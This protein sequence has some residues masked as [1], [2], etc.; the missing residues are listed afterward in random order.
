MQRSSSEVR[1][2]LFGGLTAA[3]I[4]LPLAI[5]FGVLAFSPLGPDYRSQGALAG[6]YGAIFT[7]FFAAWLGGTPSQVTGP[8]GPMTVVMTNVFVHCLQ[9]GLPPESVPALAF[10]TVSLAGLIQVFLGTARV[11]TLI[12]YIPYPV[13]AG[14]MN[15]IA[16]II[17]T[18]QIPP[19]LGLASGQGLSAVVRGQTAVSWATLLVGA[20][21]FLI[22]WFAP[23]VTR[24]VPGAL[25]GLVLGTG[26]YYLLSSTGAKLGPV[27]GEIPSGM[28]K[29]T[30][31][32]V[33]PSLLAHLPVLLGP[34]L[35]LAVLGSLDSL[36]TSLV[37]DAAT[38]TRHNSNRELVGQGVGNFLSG[39]F[40]GVAGAGATVRTMVNIGAG[41]RNRL[42]GIAHSVVLLL[43]VLV[44]GPWAG[45]IPLVVLAGILMV[46]AIRMIDQWSGSLAYRFIGTVRQ[47]REIALNLA[48]VALVTLVTVTVDLMVAVGI[49]VLVAA[50]LF[51]AKMRSSILGATYY[52]DT[53]Y[54]RRERTPLEIDLLERR[55]HSTAIL[56]LHGPLFFGSADELVVAVR[57][58][59]PVERIIIDF[60]RVV[61]VDSSGARVLQLLQEEIEV[62]GG[63]LA[64]C[65]IVR[66]GP[67]WAFLEDLGV[68]QK[69]GE[70]YVFSDLDAALEWAENEILKACSEVP[71][72]GTPITFEE[73][74][75]VRGLS[76]EEM[77][78]LEQYLELEEFQSGDWLARAGEK[79]TGFYL[80][81]RGSA[82]AHQETNGARVRRLASF[83]PGSIVGEMG[84]VSERPRSANVRA[85]TEVAA[86]HMGADRFRLLREEHPALACKL[87]WN[88]ARELS[89]RLRRAHA[90]ILV[91][92]GAPR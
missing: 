20:V 51:I 91:L 18:S 46:T 92:E 25:L 5:A 19:V 84:V 27:I 77:S 45:R 15:G 60:R 50:A 56:E 22:V 14:F 17:F 40:G 6:L 63:R 79:S 59:D 36:L 72:P 49:G 54:S 12:K 66:Q 85:D 90:E 88:I 38:R 28:P 33:Y 8:T 23:R 39:C 58:L 57:K 4:A 44:F 73:L 65:N 55:G 86:Y 61:E 9:R 69:I 75:F 70:E 78:L 43:V 30:Y 87:L 83:G 48:V 35:V 64:L 68:L 62:S 74:E 7:G 81:V 21:T 16:I 13:T 52:G 11:G 76:P 31:L 24:V 89:S 26:A 32:L 2:D 80:L 42:S 82:S 47:K 67:R 1:S 34:A 53:V 3:I 71:C 10:F 29:P 37:A 41:G